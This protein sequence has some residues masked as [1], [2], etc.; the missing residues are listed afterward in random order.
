MFGRYVD[1]TQ[2]SVAI[3]SASSLGSNGEWIAFVEGFINVNLSIPISGT[4]GAVDAPD[5]VQ[6][7][8]ATFDGTLAAVDAPD[9]VAITGPVDVHG[10]LGAVESPDEVTAAGQVLKHRQTVFFVANN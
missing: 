3:T 1:T 9:V 8:R 10:T 5:I 6:F 7:V 4:L 2:S